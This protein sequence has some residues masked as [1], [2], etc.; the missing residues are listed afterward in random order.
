M[1]ATIAGYRNASERAAQGR[2]ARSAAP[3]SA[4]AEWQPSPDRPDPVE[5]LEQQARSRVPELVP[6]RYGR[7]LTSPLAFFRGAAAIMA[8]DLASTPTSGITVQLCGDAHLSNFGAFAAPDRRLVFDINDFD[9]TLPGPWEWDV[10]RLAVS[11]AVAARFGGFDDSASRRIVTA[12]VAAYRTTMRALAAMRNLDVWYARVEADEELA[13]LRGQA[14]P[15]ALARARRRTRQAPH[16]DSLRAFDKLTR[17]IDGERRIISDP[18]IVVPIRELVPDV[19]ADA[20]VEAVEEILASYRRSL[21]DELR[22]LLES[23]RFVDLARKV[24]GVGSVGTRAW[25]ALLLG[26]DEGDPLFLQVKEAEASVL[27][28]FLGA[29]EYD[30]HGRRVVEG[31]RLLQTAP[32]VMLGW[33]SA[34]GIDGRERDF[35]VRQLWDWK[36]SAEVE[37][38]APQTLEIYGRICAGTLARGHGRS[39]DRVGIAAYLGSGPAFDRAIAAFAQTYADQNDRDHRTLASAVEQGR[40][41]ARAGV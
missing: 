3:R 39:A 37:V 35:Y 24:V 11:L 31:Q 28:P 12:A 33:T 23:Y 8:A 7:M 25:I 4:H 17:E 2:A 27:E 21:R 22:R 15:K 30:Q 19:E 36:L 38:M 6:I 9:E 13:R 41:E 32:D 5:L 10:K 16:K 34:T 40:V 29:S 26:R 1:A 14:S 18:P 20:I